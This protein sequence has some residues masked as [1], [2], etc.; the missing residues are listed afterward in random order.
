VASGTSTASIV[1]T[2]PS[3][4]QAT[5]QYQLNVTGGSNMLAYDANGN[6]T[7]DGSRTFEWD[8]R[9]QLVAV[10]I[11]M[12]RSEFSYDGL[13][14][15]V[16]EV[17]KEDGVPVSDI[18]LVWCE[19]EICEER[20]T[21]GVTV[22]RRAFAQ[23]EQVVGVTHFFAVDHLG[24]VRDVTNTTGSLL[25]RYAFDPWGRR[26][27]TS[28][29]DVTTVGFTGHRKHAASGLTLTLYRGYD[30]GTGRWISEDP[31]GLVG[32]TNSYGYVGGRPVVATD[33][34]GL[35]VDC[36]DHF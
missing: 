26:L 21:D 23:G 1:A 27:V 17:E 5:K 34:L 8:A 28:G 16:R 22:T 4:N 32:G 14:R 30:T 25:A 35:L 20:A 13:Q 15:R 24:S 9:N 10:T 11:G 36:I 3:G 7:S 33:P 2:D 31:L 6:R 29:T 19:D 12:H 18:K